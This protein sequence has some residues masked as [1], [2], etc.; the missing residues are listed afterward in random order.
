M[1]F[2]GAAFSELPFSVAA[3]GA[4]I[5]SVDQGEIIVASTEVITIRTKASTISVQP[6]E[7]ITVRT[8]TPELT[9]H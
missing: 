1:F 4:G 8:A 2:G 7:T 5:A 6:T 9:V 3:L